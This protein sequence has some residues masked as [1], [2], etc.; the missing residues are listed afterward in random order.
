MSSF[1]SRLRHELTSGW[2]VTAR[3]NQLPPLGDWAVWLMLAGRGF[4]KTRVLSEMTNYWAAAGQAGRI[5]ITAGH[6]S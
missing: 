3:P 1:T 2:Q 5:A 6:R 4:G